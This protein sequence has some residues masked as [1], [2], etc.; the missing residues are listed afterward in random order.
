MLS[1]GM[2]V[3]QRMETHGADYKIYAGGKKHFTTVYKI[4][5]EYGKENCKLNLVANY[6][7]HSKQALLKREG[8]HIQSTEGV[9]RCVAGRTP[10]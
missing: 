1:S 2:K 4:F 9:N 5:N 10:K 7:C 8:F 3:E 6:P